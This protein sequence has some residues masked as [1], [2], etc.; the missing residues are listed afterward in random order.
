MDGGISNRHFFC[1]VGVA[2]IT[3][4]MVK[5]V[6]NKWTRLLSFLLQNVS[7]DNFGESFADGLAFCAL[8][9]H[10]IPDQIPY[11]QLTEENRVRLFKYLIT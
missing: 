5:V 6:N 10:F 3:S 7:I 4:S 8:L 11:A 2:L 9:H 1:E